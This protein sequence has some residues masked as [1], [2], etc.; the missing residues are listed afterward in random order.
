MPL[1]EPPSTDQLT[2]SAAVARATRIAAV[3][4]QVVQI[5]PK[6]TEAEFLPL[7]R[8]IAS[9]RLSGAAASATAFA[10]VPERA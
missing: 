5:I 4:A 1:K 9:A 8:D 3:S 7:R 6:L 2:E 10:P